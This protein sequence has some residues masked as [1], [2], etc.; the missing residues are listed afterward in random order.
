MGTVYKKTVTRPLPDGAT[1]A[2]KRRKATAK[3]LRKDSTAATIVETIATWHDRAGGKRTG[4]VVVG[5]DG[6]QRVRSQSETYYAKYRDGV[7]IVRE[8]P[9]GCRDVQAAKAKLAELERT[10][11]RVRVGVLS[12]SDVKVIEHRDTLLA[13]HL[14][15]YSVSM[16]VAGDSERHIADT[17]RLIGTLLRDCGFRTLRDIDA[18]RIEDWLDTKGKQGS[19]P[20]TRNSYLQAIKTFGSWCVKSGRLLQNPLERLSRIDE[21]SDRRRQRR[22]LTEDEL[23]RL[24]FVARWRPLAE[25]GRTV[26]TKTGDD[27]PSDPQSRK[28]WSLA[29]LAFD[30]IQHAVDLAQRKLENNTAFLEELDRRGRERALVYKVAVLTGLRRGEIESLTLGHLYLDETTPVLRMKPQDT[31]NREAVDI[32]LRVDLADDLR[33]WIATKA[34]A[35][36]VVR[37]NG[38][39][40][41][42][43]EPLFHVPKQLVK[44]L[45]RD[46]A[47]AGIAKVDDRG[48]TIDVHALRH[49][50][51]TLLSRGGVAPRTAQQAMRHSDVRLTMNVYTDP[52]LLDVAGAVDALPALPIDRESPS[53]EKVALRATGTDSLKSSVAPM[54]APTRVDLVQRRSICDTNGGVGVADPKTKKPLESLGKPRV[55][56]SEVDGSRTRNLRIDSPGTNPDATKENIGNSSIASERC[57]NGCTC[58]PCLMQLAEHLRS[59]LDGEQRRRLADWLTD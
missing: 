6:S 4:L 15:A 35:A 51:G 29:P 3:E 54:V 25:F 14:E 23:R 10:A 17:K 19:A 44:C 33:Q 41:A 18:G 50:F 32:P 48:R 49:T 7:G 47:A 2:T 30:G 42:T 46:L 37:M 58:D 5:S 55:L 40:K 34:K 53:S 1:I 21:T 9:T 24:L 12:S 26:V 43:D 28:T 52:R 39:R 8:V 11:D 57:T 13:E 36:K 22:A 56:T 31:K 16:R 27:R 38:K 45:D 20:R 59:V